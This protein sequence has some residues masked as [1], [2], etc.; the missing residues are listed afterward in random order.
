MPTYEYRIL[1]MPTT[2]ISVLNERVN[3]D[4]EDG[5]EPFMMCG[6]DFLNVM[7]RREITDE[8]ERER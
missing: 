8:S 1:H 5:W 6:N 4:A 2:S 7:L 3:S